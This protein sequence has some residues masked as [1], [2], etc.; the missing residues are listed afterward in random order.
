MTTNYPPVRSFRRRG[1]MNLA[2][3]KRWAEHAPH[4]CID[5]ADLA[6]WHPSCIDIGF[7]S[8]ESV[9]AMAAEK[10]DDRLLGV[11]V[12]EAGITRLITALAAGEIGNVKV[13][14]HDI[15]EVLPHLERDTLNEIVIFFPDPWPKVAHAGRRLVRPD[16]IELLVDHLAPGG[17]LRLATDAAH[18]AQQMQDVCGACVLLER[19]EPPPR[20]LTKYERLGT[21]AGRSITD[22]AYRRRTAHVG[23]VDYGARWSASSD[24]SISQRGMGG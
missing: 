13:V 20:V 24:S 7:G 11:E 14:R 6:A 17:L 16:V 5:V 21:E 22:L 2:R 3:R 23:A 1:R 15:L 12:H 19:V 4:Y 18:Y 10:P 8:G 9:L